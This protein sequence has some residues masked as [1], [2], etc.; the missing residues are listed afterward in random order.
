[1][2]GTFENSPKIPD[3]IMIPHGQ[4]IGKRIV[5]VSSRGNNNWG[6]TD[7]YVMH[8]NGR[9]SQKLINAGSNYSPSWSPD[10]ERITF[11][12]YRG[13]KF[14]GIYVMDADGGNPQRLTNHPDRD[15]LPTWSPD[16]ERHC[17]C[18]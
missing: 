16:S 2:A 12:S 10:G 4:L 7:I 11:M 18:I 14:S 1:M 15:F 3:L 13:D 17:L 6:Q 8:T 9:N 5:F